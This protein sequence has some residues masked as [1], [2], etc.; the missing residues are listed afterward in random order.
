M[1]T[2]THVSLLVLLL[3]VSL[4][5]RCRADPYGNPSPP[6]GSAVSGKTFPCGM[7]T[8]CG[9][10]NGMAFACPRQ[11]PDIK[12]SNPKQKGCSVDCSSQKCEAVCKGLGANC[13]GRGAGCQDPRFIGGDGVMFYFHGKKNEHFSLVSDYGL[14]VNARFIGRRPTGRSR[15][16]T[17]IQGLGL[18]FGSNSFTLEANKVAQ[19][20]DQVD[21][22]RFT[23]NG[24]PLSIPP[25]HLSAW[26]APDKQLL[27]VERTAN[28]NRVTVVLPGLVEML[29]N[30]VPVTKED[31]RI[32]KYQIPS[33]D[34]FAHL[35]VQFKFSHLSEDVEGV[36]G[37]TYRPGFQSPVKRGVPMPVMGGEDK[38]KTSS[39]VSADCK[40][41]IFATD[42][43]AANP[44]E[45]D[46]SMTVD[47][48]SKMSNG[49]GIA[50]RR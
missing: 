34:C 6:P 41:C 21:Q 12:P 26:T 38:F 24:M 10:N 7:G 14:Q 29:V 13:N 18:M 23:Y 3:A 5:T 37:Q 32:H 46:P 22:L 9:G 28:C 40:R 45:L 19:W 39:L 50:C 27:A 35:E 15:D 2:T 31:D 11:C 30:V 43:S 8:K 48:T 42:A 1:S 4:H 17:W 33:D 20:D 36:L 47:C 44:L 16:N 25:V 49:R